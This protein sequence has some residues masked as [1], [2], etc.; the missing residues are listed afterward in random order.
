M[1]CRSLVSHRRAWARVA[2]ATV[3]VGLAVSQLLSPAGATT[4]PSWLD[5]VAQ[6]GQIANGQD[7]TLIALD[8]TIRDALNG[9]SEGTAYAIASDAVRLLNPLSE[10][11]KVGPEFAAK[12]GEAFGEMAEARVAWSQEYSSYLTWTALET[13]GSCVSNPSPCNAPAV[14]VDSWYI[15]GPALAATVVGAKGPSSVNKTV[16]TTTVDAQLYWSKAMDDLSELLTS[17]SEV[18]LGARALVGDAHDFTGNKEMEAIIKVVGEH[19]VAHAMGTLVAYGTGLHQHLIAQSNMMVDCSVLGE[20]MTLGT[21][22]T[23]P[24]AKQLAEC[25]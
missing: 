9:T 22:S 25:L 16:Y 24:T 19:R 14:S 21:L 18:A 3:A 4:P 11:V 8:A 1:S 2:V 13:A 5:L 20:R 12:K 7:K 6:M 23:A 10:L 17:A 15:G